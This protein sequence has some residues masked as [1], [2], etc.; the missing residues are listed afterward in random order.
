MS[1]NVGLGR[2]FIKHVGL[3]ACRRMG[4]IM[5]DQLTNAGGIELAFS[6]CIASQHA[7]TRRTVEGNELAAN[8]LN[9][10]VASPSDD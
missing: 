5:T 7:R 8:G 2:Y 4:L 10:D 9:G 1:M 6:A 3:H